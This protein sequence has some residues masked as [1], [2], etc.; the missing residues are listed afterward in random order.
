MPGLWA[1]NDA[2]GVPYKGR[3]DTFRI[4]RNSQ[5]LTISTRRRSI[6]SNR[7]YS[8]SDPTDAGSVL[9]DNDAKNA[10]SALADRINQFVSPGSACPQARKCV[11]FVATRLAD[12]PSNCHA[13]V[14]DRKH[15]T[16]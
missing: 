1:K 11:I 5:K 15:T 7:R 13:F 10:R 14:V 6:V 2:P 4:I 9:D 16:P 12:D 3:W 8:D